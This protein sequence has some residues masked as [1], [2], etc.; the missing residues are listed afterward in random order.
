MPAFTKILIANR[1]EIACRIQR[2][3][4]ALGYRTVAVYSDADTD[5]L[6]VQMADEAVHI[7]RAPVQQSYLN[8]EAILAAAQLTGA[9]AI[10][11]G[12]GFLS[13]NPDF[14]RACQQATLTFIGPSAEA[15]EL[16]GSKRLS[17][18]AMLD[19]GVPC[20][21][22]YQGSAQDDATLQREAERIGFPLMIK[23]S[24][25]GGGRGMRLVH[26]REQLL[27]QLRTA[28]SEAMNAFGSDE[29]ILEQALI[30]PR[31][32]EVQLFGDS[33][34]NLIY[35]GER[36][37]SIQR[38]HQK[39]IEEAPCPVMTPDL[40]QAMGEA[41][42]K[43]GRAVN[44]VGAG[45]VEFLLDRNG[46][47]Y[48]LEMNTRLQVEH[49]VTEMI[50]GLDLVDWQLQIA[51]GQPL[52]LT[53]S[54]V[55]LTGHAMEVRLY[56]EDPAQGFLP[57]TG[58]VL[59]WEPAPGV[60]IDHGLLEG[61]TVS[62]FYDPMLGKI[63][64][65]GASREEA[66]RKLLRAVEDSVLLG[67]AT[68]QRL[69]IDLLKHPDFINGD[70]STGLIAEHFSV[71]P[72]QTATAE[73]LKL[74]AALFYQHSA[75]QHP[76]TL[77]RWRNTASVPVTYRLEVNG[78]LHSVSVDDLQLTTDGRHASLVINGI[79]RRIAY[80][81]EGNRLW[82]PGLTVTDR[83]QQVASRQADASSGTVQA[84]MDGAIVDI[85]VCVGET[86]SKGQLLLV[87]EA[88]K[89]EHPLKAGIDGTVKEMRVMTGDQVRNRQ[90]LLEIE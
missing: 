89:M 74:A 45:T 52:P 85:R 84:P 80:H 51:A 35:L 40:R 5:A 78:Q 48:F 37:C 21:A 38:R 1:G 22:G 29:L 79:R 27:E 66:R 83:T 86:V 64:A 33:H 13:E 59:R 47:F 12:Y 53:Q 81:L 7:G 57:Q 82:L 58:D 56:A 20:I 72:Q 46:Q 70:F 87:L 6:H 34:G 18:L 54:Q 69:L 30:D 23:A 50:T 75:N 9:D 90:V 77:A 42:L 88:M 28:R 67:V 19:A 31:H 73:Q 14:A 15:I 43:A 36:D 32:V 65:H 26:Q 63:I 55:T 16:M 60:R 10:H 39:V 11:P 76:Q 17:K 49:P 61:Q 25:G 4:Q 71:I 24:A 68:N 62:P 3:A 2:T 41:A 8:T 44:Y